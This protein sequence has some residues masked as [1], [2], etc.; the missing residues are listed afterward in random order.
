MLDCVHFDYFFRQL[1]QP[2][3]VIVRLSVSSSSVFVHDVVRNLLA[4]G[5][6]SAFCSKNCSGSRVAFGFIHRSFLPRVCVIFACLLLSVPSCVRVCSERCRCSFVGLDFACCHD[7]V[8]NCVAHCSFT[9][10][11]CVQFEQCLVLP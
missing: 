11:L 2:F 8:S 10:L 3:L 6:F 7:L 4:C 5:L 9:D 1:S